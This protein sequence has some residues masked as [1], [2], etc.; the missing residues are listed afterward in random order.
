MRGS[1][2]R[3]VAVASYWTDARPEPYRMAV[4]GGTMSDTLKA[5]VILV[6]GL[7]FAAILNGGIYQ[8]VVA[9]D[10]PGYRLNRLTGSVQ[11]VNP[12]LGCTYQ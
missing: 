4:K 10:N 7:V 9:S 5:V 12:V 2:G 3:R 8:I 6:I 1:E 11:F